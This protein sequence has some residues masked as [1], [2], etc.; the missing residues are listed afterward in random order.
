MA[1]KWKNTDDRSKWE[2]LKERNRDMAILIGGTFLFIGLCFDV[3]LLIFRDEMGDE[4]GIV[5]GILNNLSLAAGLVM[6]LDAFM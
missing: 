6:I 2:V 4:G 5:I 1:T 3:I